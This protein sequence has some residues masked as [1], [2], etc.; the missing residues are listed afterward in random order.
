MKQILHRKKQNKRNIV[1]DKIKQRNYSNWKI[2][3]EPW[4]MCWNMI[5]LMIKQQRRVKGK[6]RGTKTNETCRAHAV[7]STEW[8]SAHSVLSLQ[9]YGH[10]AWGVG[11]GN[12]ELD[13]FLESDNQTECCLCLLL[14]YLHL[15]TLFL[16]PVTLAT[17]RDPAGSQGCPQWY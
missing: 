12:W 7:V 13:L 1:N 2:R 3:F 9:C 8:H 15:V 11:L 5:S 16:K 14:R 6:R 17:R 10:A 4:Q